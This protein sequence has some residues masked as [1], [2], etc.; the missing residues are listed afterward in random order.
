MDNFNSV[1]LAFIVCFTQMAFLWFRTVNIKATSDHNIFKAI[2]SGNGLALVW[3]VS[4]SIGVK[5]IM[6]GDILPIIGHLVGGTIGTI[7]G[8]K[9][10]ESKQK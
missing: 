5:S 9:Y 1:E 2:W 10:Y 4:V 8:I 3:I 6:N 7:F